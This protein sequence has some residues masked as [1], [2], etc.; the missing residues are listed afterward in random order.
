MLGAG[1]VCREVREGRAHA[2]ENTSRKKKLCGN[3]GRATETEGTAGA[4]ALMRCK[5][6]VRRMGSEARQGPPSGQW[7]AFDSDWVRQ[8]LRAQGLK[9]EGG[10]SQSLW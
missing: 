2:T 10:R 5:E 8:D 4:K 7:L 6:R 3:L 9:A 1:S